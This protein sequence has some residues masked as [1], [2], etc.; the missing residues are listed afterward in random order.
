[1]SFWSSLLNRLLWLGL[2]LGVVVLVLFF[3]RGLRL[4]DA[5][6][7]HAKILA[8]VGVMI[9]L[10]FWLRDLGKRR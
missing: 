5:I 1:M 4:L 6:L 3:P 7:H 2:F 10:G 9:W 8:I